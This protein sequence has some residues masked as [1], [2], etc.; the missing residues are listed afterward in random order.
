[1]LI[2]SF[3]LF[4]PHLFAMSWPLS[5]AILDEI[6]HRA[7]RWSQLSL[8]KQNKT[9]T[10]LTYALH[11]A[12]SLEANKTFF[13]HINEFWDNQSPLIE[14]EQVLKEAELLALQSAQKAVA[15]WAEAKTSNGKLMSANQIIFR[16]TEGNLATERFHEWDKFLTAE[17]KINYKSWPLGGDPSLPEAERPPVD[18][19][20]FISKNYPGTPQKRKEEAK[21]QAALSNQYYG[22]T[23]SSFNVPGTGSQGTHYPDRSP[24]PC[25]TPS[26]NAPTLR[27][28]F[29]GMQ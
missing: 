17:G 21:K 11:L 19:I 3:F 20:K 10:K 2:L 27:P 28:E 24:R 9:R 5:D 26:S 8:E 25:G 18:L 29:N 1:M 15:K 22:V 16:L 13:G 12:G 7:H 23:R 14:K 4:T 6:L